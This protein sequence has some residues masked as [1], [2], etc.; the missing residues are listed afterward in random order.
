MALLSRGQDRFQAMLG[1][2]CEDVVRGAE[3][4]GAMLGDVE[5][6]E[7]HAGQLRQIEQG[8]D[9]AIHGLVRALNGSYFS[10]LGREEWHTLAS[11][12]REVLGC[13]STTADRLLMYRIHKVPSPAKELAQIIFQQSKALAAAVAVLND[14]SRCLD[15]CASVK[16]LQGDAD[17]VAARALG[18]LFAVEGDAFT[19]IKLK[20]L[21]R[22]LEGAAMSAKQAAERVEGVAVKRGA[23]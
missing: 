10:F 21:Y 16:R 20:D 6:A 8:C 23:A 5:R 2:V 15:Y 22:T 19:V 4:L 13:A 14:G 3:I 11:S 7:V 1:R 12:L 17:N 18:E 9:K